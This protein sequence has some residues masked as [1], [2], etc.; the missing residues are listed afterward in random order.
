[1]TNRRDHYEV[2]GVKKSAAADEIKRAYRILSKKYHPDRNPNDP[3][4]EGKFKE[5][6]HAYGVLSDAKKRAQCWS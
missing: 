2:L 3:S 4:A 1:M 5:V 6:Q